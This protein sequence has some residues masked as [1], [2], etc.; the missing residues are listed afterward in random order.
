MNPDPVLFLPSVGA[1][2]G[3][4]DGVV[5]AGDGGFTSPGMTIEYLLPD[6]VQKRIITLTYTRNVHDG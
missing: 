4:S 3:V 2:D 1:S 5:C 6:S